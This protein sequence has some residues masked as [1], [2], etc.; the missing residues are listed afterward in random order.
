L[1]HEAIRIAPSAAD[2]A[3]ALAACLA[4]FAGRTAADCLA[5]TVPSAAGTCAGVSTAQSGTLVW[6]DAYPGWTADIT[7]PGGA[8]TL[9]VYRNADGDARAKVVLAGSG[10]GS[11]TTVPLTYVGCVSG[12]MEFAGG[13]VLLCPPGSGSASASCADDTFRVRVECGPCLYQQTVQTCCCPE[14]IS[15]MLC[16]KLSNPTGNC[17]FLDGY[18]TV[19]TYK[20]FLNGHTYSWRDD[21]PSPFIFECDT[22]SGCFGITRLQG[23]GPGPFGCTPTTVSSLVGTMT[24][25]P[26]RFTGTFTFDSGDCCTGTVDFEIT[27]YTPGGCG[28]LAPNPF[29]GCAGYSAATALSLTVNGN[30]YAGTYDATATA[31]K[32]TGVSGMTNPVWVYWYSPGGSFPSGAWILQDGTGS[33]ATNPRGSGGC[34]ASSAACGP[35]ALTFDQACYGSAG[36][37]TSAVVT[38]P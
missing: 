6:D 16:V 24:C 30:T 32:F 7:T 8:G 14:P 1:L 38:G 2:P 37:A 3:P 10:S 26:F 13:G 27:P 34:P 36:Q 9:V 18:V 21:E 33:A 15:K 17:G 29:G 28:A 23:I 20:G 4:P 35:L 22:N 25:G 5:Y 11:A 31:W 12:G 19:L